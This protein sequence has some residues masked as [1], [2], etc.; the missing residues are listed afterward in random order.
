[1][2]IK[3]Y[4]ADIN[5]LKPEHQLLTIE[6]NINEISNLFK[7]FVKT[8]P[9]KKS[10]TKEVN[11]LKKIESIKSTIKSVLVADNEAI[12]SSNK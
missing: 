4:M 5:T 12:H 2:S 7:E 9:L 8:N 1:M 10:I 6:T 11:L 3:E